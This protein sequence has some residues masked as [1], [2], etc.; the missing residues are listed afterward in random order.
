MKSDDAN[1]KSSMTENTT[2]SDVRKRLHSELPSSKKTSLPLFVD[3]LPGTTRSEPSR[4]QQD[5]AFTSSYLSASPLPP[6]VSAARS[7]AKSFRWEQGRP[8]SVT[9]ELTD[10][11]YTLTIHGPHAEGDPDM[12]AEKW[13]RAAVSATKSRDRWCT[14]ALILAV[15]LAGAITCCLIV[16]HP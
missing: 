5:A 13:F 9:E 4:E 11:A 1:Q 10:E 8:N 15:M 3:T 12:I 7:E 16:T 6:S 14:A 2:E